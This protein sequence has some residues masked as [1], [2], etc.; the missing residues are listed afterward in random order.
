[1]AKRNGFDHVGWAEIKRGIMVDV[2]F[3]KFSQNRPLRLALLSTVGSTLV[4]ASQYDRFWGIGL[5]INDPNVVNPNNWRGANT[6]GQV[7]GEVREM[8]VRGFPVDA[9]NA[10][11]H[12]NI[13]E[14]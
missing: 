12:V 5:H 8:L 3:A 6:L 13:V 4:E 11:K 10:N 9:A 14:K 7:L 2:C 1:M